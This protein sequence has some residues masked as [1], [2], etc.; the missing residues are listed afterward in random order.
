[1][2]PW[3]NRLLV[4]TTESKYT[5]DLRDARPAPEEV[6]DLLNSFVSYF[7]T[8]GITRK[9]I[10]CACAGVRP[11]IAQSL[12]SENC[13]SRRHR[14]DVDRDRR[15][16][17]VTGGKLTTFRLMGEQTVDAVGKLLGER[18]TGWELRRRLRSDPLWPALTPSQ[19][20]ELRL[21]L[22]DQF[23]NGRIDH[24]VIDHLVRHYGHD[25]E[26]I[27]AH[28]A[29]DPKLGKPICEELPYTLAELAYLS[30]TEQVRSLLDLVKR[31]TSLYFLSDNCGFESL[32]RI[33]D[34]VAPILGWSPQRRTEETAKVA[35]EFRADMR[36]VG[37]GDQVD[38]G[39]RIPS[40][41]LNSTLVRESVRV[42][43]T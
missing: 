30:R 33:V 24:A 28:V 26:T 40:R 19:T 1:V 42:Y 21:R 29:R 17:T 6:D 7:P 31:R 22:A 5:G 12:D 35:D 37:N 4:G 15:L 16:V 14:I 9:D 39:A 13:L 27:L 8:L 25:T 11:I 20:D 3:E 2:V 36:A 38:A 18:S 10:R 41:T 34:H 23:G 32:S 43:Q